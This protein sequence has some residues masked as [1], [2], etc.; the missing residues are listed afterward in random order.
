MHTLVFVLVPRSI[1]DIKSEVERLLGGSENAPEKQF[2]QFEASCNCIGRVAIADSYR[3]FDNS[4]EGV[5]LLSQLKTARSNQNKTKEE[6]LLVERFLAM[7]KLEKEHPEYRQF[8]QECDLC[9]G[10]GTYIKTGDPR[11]YWDYW[12][13]GGRWSVFFDTIGTFEVHNAELQGCVSLIKNIPEHMIPAA[14]VTPDG[15]WFES[16][17]TI[18][19]GLFAKCRDEDELLSRRL[20]ELKAKDLLS[21]YPQHLAVVVDCHS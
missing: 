15:N 3:T 10:S 2:L 21:H 4:S 16:P 9:Q 17:I 20:W 19:D 14:I 1:V 12:L 13:I 6:K 11:A 18:G 7:R 8:D 5:L